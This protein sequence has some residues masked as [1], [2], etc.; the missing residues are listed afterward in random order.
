MKTLVTAALILLFLS[1]AHAGD[2]AA[3]AAPS[4][5][6]GIHRYLIE[7]TFPRGAL[8]GVNSATKEKVNANNATLGVRWVHS[9]VNADKTKTYCVYEGPSEDAVRQA[10]KLSALPVDSVTEIP[11]DLTSDLK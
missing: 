6:S 10:A 2:T 9:Y 5:S 4:A 3:P 1:S 8:D 7:R 11:N